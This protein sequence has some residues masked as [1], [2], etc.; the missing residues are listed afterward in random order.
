MVCA[1]SVSV[2]VSVSMSVSVSLSLSL[3]LPLPLTLSL[4]LFCRGKKGC[5]SLPNMKCSGRNLP[6]SH[7]IQEQ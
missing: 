4:S 6:A 2:S 1:V 7:R 3:S 5:T